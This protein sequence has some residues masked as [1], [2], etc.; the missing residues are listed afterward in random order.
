MDVALLRIEVHSGVLVT[1]LLSVAIG[2]CHGSA[3]VLGV[4]NGFG[5]D[6]PATQGGTEV[7]V[8]HGD[9]VRKSKGIWK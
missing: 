6:V 1:K 2:Q 5:E 4:V 7:E 9:H 8:G 3:A